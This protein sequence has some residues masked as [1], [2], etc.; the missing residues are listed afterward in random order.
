[1]EGFHKV[2]IL[3]N[4]RKLRVTQNTHSNRFPIWVGYIWLIW[5]EIIEILP[6]ANECRLG[7]MRG[8]RGV[9]DNI[10]I[11]ARFCWN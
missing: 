9:R 11:A 8:T 7:V 2:T 4:K 3:I 1:M 5:P 10:L 6:G